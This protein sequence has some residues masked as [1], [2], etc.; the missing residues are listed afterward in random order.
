MASGFPPSITSLPVPINVTGAMTNSVFPLNPGNPQGSGFAD[1]S[2][3]IRAP[4]VTILEG[5][6]EANP[7][8]G[9]SFSN[10]FSRTFSVTPGAIVNVFLFVRGY[11][12]GWEFDAFAD[13]RFEV[14][15]LATFDFNG[16]TIHFADVVTFEYSQGLVVP[17]PG[18]GLLA[19]SALLGLICAGRRRRRATA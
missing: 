8:Q 9:T 10:S 14:D 6:P 4:G 11:G 19:V 7:G 18:S 16:E 5:P 1:S 17:E 12:F 15:P 13:P 2:V 3:E